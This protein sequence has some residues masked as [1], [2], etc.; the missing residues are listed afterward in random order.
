MAADSAPDPRLFD[1][2]VAGAG[3]AGLSAALGLAKNG[4]RTLL[5]G[6]L[7]QTANGRSVALHDASV[8]WLGTLGVWS[9]VEA[10]ASPLRL[11]RLI[12]DT[13]ALFAAPT[14]EFRSQEIGL[15][16]FGWNIENRDLAGVLGAAAERAENLTWVQTSIAAYAFAKEQCALTLAD[17]RQFA[18]RL[19]V[20][21]DGRRSLARMSADIGVRSRPYEQTALTLTLAHARPHRDASS[22]FHTR[23][24]PFTL[25]PLQARP[26][27]PMRSSLVWA[28]APRDAKRRAGLSDENLAREIEIQSRSF[29]GA[30]RIESGRGVF[31]MVWQRASELTAHRLAL[32]GD[33]AHGLPPIGAQGLNLG[34][35]DGQGLIAALGQARAAGQDIG[36]AGVL[37]A[38]AKGRSF[39]I[40]SRAGIVDALNRSLLANFAP[41]D[42]ARSF[43][44]AA[45]GAIG[46]LRR[47][48]MR[49]GVAPHFAR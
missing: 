9:A 24:G 40:A 26:E 39:D 46:P 25:V 19:A 22:E 16:A 2:I 27:A 47:F 30:L 44:L 1:V 43:G 23:C 20:G 48:A 8:Q 34:L 13:G 3:L 35:R 29:L 36:A 28:M 49:E 5:C 31:P 38:Y 45:L 21:A 10:L 12:D 17:G 42:I 4:F 41:L 37:H 15:D 14:L 18:A 32:I 6:A 11:L 7:D 33:A